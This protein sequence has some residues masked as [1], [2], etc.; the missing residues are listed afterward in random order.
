MIENAVEAGELVT[1]MACETG[2]RAELRINEWEARCARAEARWEPDLH[3]RV[4][5]K[6]TH[7]YELWLL[8]ANAVAELRSLPVEHHKSLAT[9]PSSA[10]NKAHAQ[11]REELQGLCRVFAVCV[12]SRS[13]RRGISERERVAHEEYLAGSGRITIPERE[14]CHLARQPKIQE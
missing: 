10:D 2:L 9:T 3:L 11:L 8:E 7:R 14:G 6:V 13:I 4:A 12:R 5:S 1:K